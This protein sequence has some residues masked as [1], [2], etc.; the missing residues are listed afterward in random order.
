M[1]KIV[2]ILLVLSLT[3]SESYSQKLPDT[4]VS[5]I[6]N[7]FQKWDK[8]S[9]PG[10]AIGIVR[11]D[12]LIYAKGYGM[13]NLENGI[14]I[15]PET[16]FYMASVSK[17][18][19]G[20]SII[21][22]ARQGKLT[23]DDDIR[24]YLPWIHDFG[25]TLTIRHLL[26]HTSGLRDDITLA[27]ITGLGYD[28]ML[29]QELAINLIKNQTSLNFDP[30]ERYSYSNSNY[31]LL[32]EI[33]KTASGKSFRS[34]ADSAIFKPLGMVN[35]QFQD[36]YAG[37][38]KNRALSYSGTRDNKT[39]NSFQN[40]YT[41]GDGGLFSNIN[42]MA[43]WVINLYSP[44]AGDQKDI[45]QLTWKGKLNNGKEITYA[46]GIGNSIYNGRI[47]Y[48]HSGGLAGYR[49]YVS[50]F[51]EL[52]MGFIVFSNDGDFNSSAKAN[53][54]ADIFTTPGIINNANL[55]DQ[56]DNNK[57]L[58]KDISI[59]RKYMGDYVDED[60]TRL[61]FNLNE[62]KMSLNVQGQSFNLYQFSRDTIALATRP[63]TRFLFSISGNDTVA[64][65]YSPGETRIFRKYI[66]GISLTNKQL[67]SYTGTYY[68][69]E[70]DCNYG[71]ELRDQKLIL[72]SNKYEDTEISLI[73]S[74]DLYTN[75]WW[76]GHMKVLRDNKN[77][78]TGFE[79]NDGHI[80]H[81]RFIKMKE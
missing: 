30:G 27:A 55:I 19:T 61:N 56:N 17:Q 65:Q 77:M 31:V 53:E 45:E 54:M 60:G 73:G 1:K 37:L 58:I 12:T 40:V 51:P 11:N 80:M 69:L 59:F 2:F 14:P 20:Y 49:T 41:V 18:F 15:S 16:V 64:T 34:F 36:N 62:G 28:G 52:K 24:K 3:N 63:E 35:S 22:L 75:N 23:L 67:Q 57:L 42:D 39:L 7:L 10:C 5:R 4:V 81:L 47:K 32:A 76:M 33:V 48:S 79:I 25:K 21:L 13:A 72:T 68:S 6:D 74:D 78:V 8:T 29:T 38:I 9:V 44:L 70:L 26:N 66:A 71:I 43:K 46:S 50:A